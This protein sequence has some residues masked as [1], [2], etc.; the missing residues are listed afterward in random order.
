[1]TCPQEVRSAPW[2]AWVSTILG[3]MNRWGRL[4]HL[5][6]AHHGVVTL[7]MAASVG[8]SSQAVRD[9]AAA[10]G[11]RRLARGAWL[12]P[13]VPFTPITRAACELALAGDRAALGHWSA[14]HVHGLSPRPADP[15]ELV[16]PW[17]RRPERRAGVRVRRSRT[18]LT[19]DIIDVDGVRVT[20]VPRTLRDLATLVT[21]RRLYDMM[22]DAEQRR[23]VSLD[24]LTDTADRL[25]H[26][27][28]SGRFRNVVAQRHADRSD[29]AL[30]R[31]TRT[32]TR[33]AGYSPTPGPFPIRV[34]RGRRLWLDVA[35]PGVWFAIECD[36]FGFHRD[37]ASFE[38]DRERWRLAQQAGWRLTWVTRA[39]LRDD[40]GGLLREVAE[41]HAAADPSRAAAVSA[42]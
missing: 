10:E 21:E 27:P 40:P 19:T 22:T 33:S 29:S 13:G 4:A 3:A 28:G 41:A 7:T 31:D 42:A 18:L 5:A 15:P 39:R 12:L 26:G 11:W 23:L 38:R 32:V 9:R 20:T 37:R 14:A 34:A 17:D 30:E 8:L 1:M 6:A 36:G 24:Q 25:H 16:V 35:F 2:G